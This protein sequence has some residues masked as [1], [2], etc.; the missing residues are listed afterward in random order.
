MPGIDRFRALY[1]LKYLLENTDEDH[2]VT[3]VQI[4]NHLAG[5]EIEA[6]PK[7]I[8]KDITA[9]QKLG[10]DIIRNR[11]IQYQ[12]FF[13][14]RNFSTFELKLMIDAVQAAHFISKAQTEELRWQEQGKE[15][16]NL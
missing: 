15:I 6:I 16:P 11:S 3:S 9:L 2:L 10:F 14:G 8:Y 4:H 5:L 12:Y 1:L 13:A 7:T